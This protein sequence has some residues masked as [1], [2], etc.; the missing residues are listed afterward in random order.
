MEEVQHLML[1]MWTW[2][3]SLETPS[4]C[5]DRYKS[6]EP[7]CCGVSIFKGRCPCVDSA[8]SEQPLVPFRSRN[9]SPKQTEN[10]YVPAVYSGWTEPRCLHAMCYH[11]VQVH[12]GRRRWFKNTV[13]M[14]FSESLETLFWLQRQSTSVLAEFVRQ[15]LY[16]AHASMLMLVTLCV[17]TVTGARWSTFI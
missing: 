9:S 8:A 14:V 12:C 10:S 2:D 13:L 11:Y 16:Q 5:W 1:F 17:L 3:R 7:L 6:V 15:S 4:S